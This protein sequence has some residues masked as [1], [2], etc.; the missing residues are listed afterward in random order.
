MIDGEKIYLCCTESP[1]KAAVL[2][3]QVIIQAKGLGSKLNFNYTKAELLAVLFQRSIV[4]VKKLR[5]E[6]ENR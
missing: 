3:D 4:Q 5:H 2:Y 6:A 1:A